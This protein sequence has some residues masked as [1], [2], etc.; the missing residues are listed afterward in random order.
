MFFIRYQLITK[1][2]FLVLNAMYLEKTHCSKF[3]L[4]WWD[5]RLV[6]VDE[7]AGDWLFPCFLQERCRSFYLGLSGCLWP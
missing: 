1:D 7:C 4:L 2:V 3:Q 6:M 5:K